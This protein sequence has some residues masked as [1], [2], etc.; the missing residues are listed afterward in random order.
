MVRSNAQHRYGE[1][2]LKTEIEQS[3]GAAEKPMSARWIFPV[4]DLQIVG[5]P[6]TYSP[7][8]RLAVFKQ[9]LN[10]ASKEFSQFTDAIGDAP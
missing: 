2:P 3:G 10:Q 8:E 6:G 4:A 1:Y 7:E 5:A 9:D